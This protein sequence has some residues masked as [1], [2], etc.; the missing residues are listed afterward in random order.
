VQ[1]RI[2]AVT[3][4][5]ILMNN[6]PVYDI[7]V[8]YLHP[9]LQKN[10]CFTARLVVDYIEAGTLAAGTQIAILVDRENPERAVTADI[11][12]T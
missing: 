4:T 3:F 2:T 6:Q 10:Y 12:E 9:M 8:E 5:N 7:E 11:P 1:G